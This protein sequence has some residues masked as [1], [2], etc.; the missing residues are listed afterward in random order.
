MN[1]QGW[2]EATFGPTESFASLIMDFP[3]V[4]F[5]FFGKTT[6]ED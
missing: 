1:F 6:C 3:E 2:M 4:P 5:V